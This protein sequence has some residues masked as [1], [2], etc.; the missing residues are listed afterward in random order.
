[1]APRTRNGQ[2]RRTRAQP[3]LRTRPR[4]SRARLLGCRAPTN[5]SGRARVREV[6][7]GTRLLHLKGRALA[8]VEPA[9]GRCGQRVLQRAVCGQVDGGAT[10][11]CRISLQKRLVAGIHLAAVHMDGTSALVSV[12]VGKIRLL[13][14]HDGTAAG[15]HC[16]TFQRTAVLDCALRQSQHR[17]I[18]TDRTSRV[19]S[20]HCAR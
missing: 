9:S 17:R 7:L 13:D 19:A 5:N 14:V 1:M 20:H 6:G 4:T 16:S 3:A 11:G 10:A 18:H 8:D 12:V 15:E 2:H